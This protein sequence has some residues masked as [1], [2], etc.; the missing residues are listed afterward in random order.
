MNAAL[1]SRTW[2]GCS[3]AILLLTAGCSSMDAVIFDQLTT[4][5]SS[6]LGCRPSRSL[7]TLTRAFLDS[8]AMPLHARLALRLV[9]PFKPARPPPPARTSGHCAQLTI[10]HDSCMPVAGHQLH[11]QVASCSYAC[12]VR[13]QL[14][15]LCVRSVRSRSFVSESYGRIVRRDGKCHTAKAP[16]RRLRACRRRA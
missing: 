12:R 4:C 1:R 16:C 10:G 6:A 15:R 14:F 2:Q 11:E 7:P 9:L 5:A 13:A 3:V 8:G